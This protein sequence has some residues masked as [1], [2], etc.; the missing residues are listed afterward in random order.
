MISHAKYIFLLLLLAIITSCATVSKKETATEK[1]STVSENIT[2]GLTVAS[3]KFS[4]AANIRI[5]ASISFKFPDMSNSANAVI[6]M[7]KRD[8]I[9]VTIT[10]PFG[11]SVGKLYATPNE[12]IMNNN[13]Q[14]TTFVGVPTEKN[15]MQIANIPL[16][17]N[18][19]VSILRTSTSQNA[20]NYIHNSESSDAELSAFH[21]AEFVAGTSEAGYQEFISVNSHNDVVRMER[22]DILGQTII[23]ANFS[24][25]STVEQYRF[26]KNLNLNFPTLSGSVTIR[27]SD[28]SL[29]TQP[30]TPMRFTKPRT[31]RE[32]RFE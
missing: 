2:G 20:T 19:L 32:F 26:A 5:R 9:L 21:L 29:T 11:I 17:F 28:I 3:N 31:Y 27:I 10:G 15:I 23:V 14:N 13:L 24:E 1:K 22:K 18:D 7:A 4:D 12:F 30:T 6:E 25:H 8:S 16:S